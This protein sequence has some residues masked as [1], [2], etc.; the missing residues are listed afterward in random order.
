M[1]NKTDILYPELSYRIMGC[2]FEVFNTLGPGLLKKQY[3]KAMAI[4]F[5]L[6][7]IAFTEQAYYP[8]KYKGVNITKGF[9]DFL[10]EKKIVGELKRGDHFSRGNIDQVSSYL[11]YSKLELGILI[12]FTKDGVRQKRILNIQ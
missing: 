4:E 12:H 6:R 10:V 3:Q 5:G 7:K 2:A 8:R 11:E 9:M 1:L